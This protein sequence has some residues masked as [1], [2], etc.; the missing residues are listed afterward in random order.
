MALG[1]DRKACLQD[2]HLCRELCQRHRAEP[3]DGRERLGL[4]RLA[5]GLSPTT[6]R[7]RH[8]G[9]VAARPDASVAQVPMRP[10]RPLERLARSVAADGEHDPL[11][12]A[13]GIEMA[14]HH[15]DLDRR[16]LIERKPA[17]AGPE[18]DERQ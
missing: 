5:L 17:D 1:A 7:Q 15:G 13:A 18:R 16:G 11:E 3:L 9:T 10:E 8:R 4:E 14:P 2:H 12:S 6:D